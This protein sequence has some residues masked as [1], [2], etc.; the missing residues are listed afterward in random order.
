MK[1]IPYSEKNALLETPCSHYGGVMVGSSWCQKC[2]FYCGEP[3]ENKV[4]CDYEPT[5]KRFFTR[6][7]RTL[8]ILLITTTAYSQRHDIMP[9]EALGLTSNEYKIARDNGLTDSAIADILSVG[10]TI[11]K[12]LS[13]PWKRLEITEKDW[14]GYVRSGLDSV[15]IEKAVYDEA[16]K[17]SFGDKWKEF[18]AGIRN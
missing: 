17:K 15:Q 1:S 2:K 4:N 3:E 14:Y 13:E 10:V 18:I 5:I 16:H 11:K 9:W 8:F 7:V 6:I 12:H